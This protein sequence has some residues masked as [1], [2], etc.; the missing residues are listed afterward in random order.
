M[1]HTGLALGKGQ[2]SDC[3]DGGGGLAWAISP[4]LLLL[5]S[6]GPYPW[7]AALSIKTRL[8]S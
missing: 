5:P 4:A 3:G 2:V 7:G 8:L 1:A 6:A